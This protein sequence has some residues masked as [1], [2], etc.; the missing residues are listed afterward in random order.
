MRF[1]MFFLDLKK[2]QSLKFQIKIK[3]INE[4]IE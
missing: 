2:K 1:L 3:I 4:K